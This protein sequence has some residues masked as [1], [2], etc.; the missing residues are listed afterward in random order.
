MSDY[1]NDGYELSWD[2]EIENEGSEYIVAEEGDYDFTIV[3]FERGRFNGSQKM[4]PCNQA[5][6]Y[7]KLEIPG[8]SG[9]CV[10]RDKL[11][12]HSKSEWKLCEF[13]TSIG[14]RQK[15]Q[16]VSMNWNA[17]P[18]ARGRCK[19]S[20]RS[21]EGKDGKTK[22]TNDIDKYYPAEAV[23]GNLPFH[24][25]NLPQNNPAPGGYTVGKF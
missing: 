18:G 14:Q 23:G 15:G 12:L 25:G 1:M 24:T 13:F 5:E 20:K 4:P 22:W 17:V 9:E 6:L 8:A 11:F 21:F 2:A 16:R 7:V 3:K 10:V 19:V